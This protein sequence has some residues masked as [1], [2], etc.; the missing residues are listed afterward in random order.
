MRSAILCQRLRY[1]DWSGVEGVEGLGCKGEGVG[2]RGGRDGVV[3][4]VGRRG[5][6]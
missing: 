6:G 2:W 5:W 3:V 4:G 1:M